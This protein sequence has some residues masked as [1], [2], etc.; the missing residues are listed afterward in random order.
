MIFVES[1]DS[2]LVVNIFFM[3]IGEYLKNM[4]FCN[5]KFFVCVRIIR[6][7]YGKFIVNVLVIFI[8]V[9]VIVFFN[10]K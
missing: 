1:S 7:S 2:L 4:N 5:I 3:K 10:L 6:V 9:F 8:N